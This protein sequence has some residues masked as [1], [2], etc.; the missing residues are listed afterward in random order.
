MIKN[1]KHIIFD[2]N[3]TLINDADVF[4][5]VL[6]ALLDK[7][8]M[9]RIN[10]NTYRDLFCFPIV[11]FYKKIGLDVSGDA[12][13]QLKKEFVCEYDKRK[14]VAALFPESI[15][16]L[17]KLKK[18]N[19][20]LS[21]LSASNQNTLDSLVEYYS[22]GGFFEN[23]VGVDNYIAEGKTR[24]GLKLLNAIEANRSDILLVGDTNLDYSVSQEL[25]VGCVLV[26]HGH[27]SI[28]QLESCD[29]QIIQSLDMLLE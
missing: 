11:D 25:G 9:D 21:I 3:G 28:H 5:D 6:N 12:F 4:V 22:I 1:K 13:T 20:A 18:D 17:E 8:K 27:Q 29:A 15:S 16:V 14:Y 23:V 19:L 7:R 24:R 2:W 26:S 10:L